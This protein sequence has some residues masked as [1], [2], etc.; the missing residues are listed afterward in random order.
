[1]ATLAVTRVGAATG[2]EDR[3]SRR[4]RVT[5][6]SYAARSK[7]ATP[8]FF[9]SSSG[10]VAGDSDYGELRRRVCSAIDGSFHSWSAAGDENAWLTPLVFSL[11]FLGVLL[12]DL[13]AECE[14]F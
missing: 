3:L 5:A 12:L 2:D 10:I 9:R 11:L 14:A 6:A 7:S 8:S 1:M 13:Q 4:R